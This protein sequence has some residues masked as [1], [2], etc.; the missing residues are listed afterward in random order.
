M[1]RILELISDVREKYCDDDFFADFEDSC[2]TEPKKRHYLSYNRALMTLDNDSWNVLK[3][4]AIQHFKDERIGQR[5]QAFFNQLNEAFAY[6]YLLRRGFK[7]VR[8]ISEGRRKT[9]DIRFLDQGAA[10]YCEVKTLGISV[11][12]I[13][14]RE[15]SSVRG[16]EVYLLLSAGFLGKLANHVDLAWKQVRSIGEHG[17]VFV[18]IR[19]DDIALDHY[20]TYRRQLIQFAHNRNVENVV[21]KVGELGSTGIC[22]KSLRTHRRPA[23]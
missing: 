23:A 11:D 2:Q 22:I 17:L 5:K 16:G 13:N 15:G 6:R 10:K 7:E 14:R 20:P 8:F 4:K 1:R 9:P 12:E 19:F 18:F 21:I 3:C